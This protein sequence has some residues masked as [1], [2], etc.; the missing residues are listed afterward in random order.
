MR[1]TWPWKRFRGVSQSRK[2]QDQSR[3]DGLVDLGGMKSNVHGRSHLTIGVDVGVGD[4]PRQMRCTSPAAARRETTQAADGLTENNRGCKDVGGEP[5]GKGMASEVEQSDQHSGDQS[6]V[7]D[8]A[9]LEDGEQF[10]GVARV[11]AP[12]DGE[13]EELGSHEPCQQRPNAEVRHA[14]RV[15]TGTPGADSREPQS[16]EERAASRTP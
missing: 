6:A 15:E 2:T 11:V 16:E 5:A 3:Q 8:A 14:L 7:E 4:G 1:K 10:P 9:A 13:E 12:V